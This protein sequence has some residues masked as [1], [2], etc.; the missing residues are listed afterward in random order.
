MQI[1]KGK[2]KLIKTLRVLIPD[3]PGFLGRLTTAIGEEGANIGDTE[4]IHER[5]EYHTRDITI[6]LDNTEHLKRV[7]ESI[8][9]VEGI[10]I[11]EVIDPVLELHK[12]GKIAVKS[13]VPLNS[14]SD[15]RRIYTPGVANVCREIQKDINK[16][17]D[18]T[19]I[20]NSV[21]IITN[22]T[23]VLGL[24]DIGVVAGMPVMEGKSVLFDKLVGINGIPILL[25]TKDKDEFIRSV[26]SISKT[27]GAIKLEDISAPDCFEIEERLIEK[28]DIPV[29]HDDQHGT[30]VVVLAALFNVSKYC[31]IELKNEKVGIIG[32]GAAGLG[33]SKLLLYFGID[34]LYGTDIR[35][36][37]E[38]ILSKYGGI[39]STLEEIMN[40]SD[41]VIGTTGVSSLINPH[42]VKKGQVI[43]ALSNPYPEIDP[44]E[45]LNAGAKFACDG[46]SV[47]NALAFPGIFRGALDTRANKINDRMKVAAAQTIALFA[48]KGDLVPNI[49]NIEM[50]KAVAEAVAKAA[51]ESGVARAKR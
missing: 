5:L 29:M 41:I 3:K 35:K 39:P 22:G 47:N 12:G 34:K 20:H 4:L 25:D 42:M 1:E 11:E 38:E 30:G 28:L 21:A 40:N 8:K 23:A 27:F 10:I 44:N 14:N 31:G 6:Y 37:E 48:E 45:A 17:Y 13:T 36:E 33:I 50:H 43:L 18:Y 7:L 9:R 16:A 15:L 51:F 49:M 19:S 32:L 26:I 24:G 46:K 2:D